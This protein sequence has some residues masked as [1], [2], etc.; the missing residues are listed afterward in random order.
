MT[1]SMLNA[2]NILTY[3]NI[4]IYVECGNM[5]INLPNSTEFAAGQAFLFIRGQVNE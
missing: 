1:L 2:S 5:L 3:L 4:N